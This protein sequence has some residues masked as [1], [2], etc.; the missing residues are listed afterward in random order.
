MPKGGHAG[1]N[2]SMGSEAQRAWGRMHAKQLHPWCT[3]YLGCFWTVGC[4]K[5]KCISLRIRV[6]IPFFI[7]QIKLT[8]RVG[9]WPLSKSC[10]ATHTA[11]K[12]WFFHGE[13]GKVEAEDGGLTQKG[14]T[15]LLC[16]FGMQTKIPSVKK[17]S[18]ESSLSVIYSRSCKHTLPPLSSIE[19]LKG[20]W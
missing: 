5:Q 20:L 1:N 6:F 13:E 14:L 15:Q 2:R 9:R 18:S 3:K 16:S 4:M 11:T 12:G 10:F 19:D 17:T 8:K 7:L